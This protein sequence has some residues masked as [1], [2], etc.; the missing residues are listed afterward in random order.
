MAGSSKHRVGII[1]NIHT[2]K[3]TVEVIAPPGEGRFPSIPVHSVAA[4][5][6]RIRV[7]VRCQILDVV[8][9]LTSQRTS[10]YG[11]SN[12]GLQFTVEGKVR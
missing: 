4:T 2:P 11:G 9:V 10:G 1:C 8:A 6:V 3:G 5:Q 7:G 12:L